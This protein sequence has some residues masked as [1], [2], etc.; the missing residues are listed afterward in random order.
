MWRRGNANSLTPED[1]VM[2]AQLLHPVR[3][4]AVTTRH[5]LICLM[6]QSRAGSTNQSVRK[7]VFVKVEVL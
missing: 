6:W 1:E 5:D 3:R 2:V 4:L 7:A